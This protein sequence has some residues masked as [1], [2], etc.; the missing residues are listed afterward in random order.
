MLCH[1]HKDDYDGSL[2]FG[3]ELLLLACSRCCRKRG[4]PRVHTA[5]AQP[6]WI[7]CPHAPS[8]PWQCAGLATD[9]IQLE[10]LAWVVFDNIMGPGETPPLSGLEMYNQIVRRLVGKA[11]KGL[12]KH[13]PAHTST[14]FGAEVTRVRVEGPDFKKRAKPQCYSMMRD[15]REE[16]AGSCSALKE[17]QSIVGRDQLLTPAHPVNPNIQGM[18]WMKEHQR[19]YCDVHN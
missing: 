15:V 4:E 18:K 7:G 6:P 17:K 1:L 3:H 12:H 10:C 19:S 11:Y 8:K 9:T 5:Q 14:S 16:F 13:C 2:V